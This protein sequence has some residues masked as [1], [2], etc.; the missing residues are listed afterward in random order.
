MMISERER[1]A[2]AERGLIRLDK[3][4]PEATVAPLRDLALQTLERE[5]FWR[6]GAW[7]GDPIS[8]WELEARLSRRLKAR[9]KSS[10]ALNNLM[11]ADLL[12]VVNLLVDGQTVRP[13]TDRPQVLFMSPNA[14]AWTVPHKIW[15][16]DVPRLGEVGLPGVQIFSFLNPVAPGAGGTLV[17]AGLHRLLNDRGRISSRNV[18]R[19][20]RREPY[21]RDLFNPRQS[22]RQRLLEETGHVGDVE[23]QVVELH[24]EPGDVFLMDL[25]LLHTLAPNA[26]RVPRLMVTQRFYLKSVLDRMTE[27]DSEIAGQR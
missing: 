27:L 9:L 23:L 12:K 24:G 22:D 3:L 15:H 5:G 13:R 6:D 2:F 18:K 16:L 7:L 21:F 11:T 25:R 26:S 1:E 20:L 8:D 17:V 19:S 4:I 10:A 14:T